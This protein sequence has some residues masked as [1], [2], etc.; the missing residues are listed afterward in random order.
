V[1]TP[2]ATS[3]PG[4][5]LAVM[6]VV[7]IAAAAVMF[8]I[9][10]RKPKLAID[11]A[12]GTSVTLTAKPIPGS[13]GGI[14]PQA[15]SEAVSIIR[16]RVNSTGVT[17]AQVSILGSNNISVTIP[18]QN[19]NKIVNL[20]G[21]TALLRFRPVL[22]EAGAAPANPTPTPTPTGKATTTPTAEPSPSPESGRAVSRALE[23]AAA[24]SPPSVPVPP[25]GQVP[26]APS[27]LENVPEAVQQK[28]VEIDCTA[29][30][31]LQ[32]G[33]QAKPSDYVVACHRDATAKY[34]LG[35]SAVEGTD[36]KSA[37]AG[38][39]QGP[40]AAAWQVNLTF[41]GNGTRKFADI[42]RKVVS[43]QPPQNQV[44]IVLDGLV[45]SAPRIEEAITAG[46][47]QITGDFDQASATDLANVLKYGALPLAFEKSQ[48]NTISPTL[49]S[50][51]FRGGLIAGAIGLIL[52]A[53]YCLL[54]YRAL[55]LIAVISLG[56][57]AL[58]AYATVSL[59]GETLNYRLSLAG[60]AGLIVAIGITADS[61]VVYFERLRDELRDGRSVRAAI[62]HG[63]VRARRTIIVADV[64]SFLAAAI[65]YWLSVDQVKG[66]AFTLGLIT[67][68][69]V[70]VVFLFTKP[71]VTLAGRTKLFTDGH[72]VSGVNPQ[73]LGL[74]RGTPVG[75]RAAVKEA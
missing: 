39:P 34:I 36:L 20:I 18:E 30:E 19:N 67:L 58:A 53:L 26:P 2:T 6:A 38:L 44:A 29:K 27:G 60:I 59:L 1:A 4:R 52:V 31:N 33:D 43:L 23:V 17:E 45:V 49:G 75:R 15:M 35:P 5:A 37:D 69:D 7:L 64:V 54:Y 63:W 71:V 61:F 72:R 16:Q 10:A 47:A 55:G 32:G 3:R 14:T 70:V 22:F 12:G 8:A 28:F 57:A 24:P 40:S 73:S 50:D 51:Q 11:L 74:R 56:V 46:Q 21:Q 25:T 13:T 9:D 42:T 62:E 65:L 48:V 68:I 41:D 66:F